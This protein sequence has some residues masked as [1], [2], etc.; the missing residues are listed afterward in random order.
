SRY[1]S[2]P[3]SFF[4]FRTASNASPS[5]PS[6]PTIRKIRETPMADIEVRAVERL[7]GS[8]AAYAYAV[9]AGPWLFLT[10]HE[11][12]DFASGATPEVE[13][14]A[15]FPSFGAPRLQREA[16]YVLARMRKALAE[17]GSDF[18][19]SVRVDQYYPVFEAVRA[20]QLARHG[21]FGDY[22][23]PSTSV[24]MERLF[25]RDSHLSMSLMAVVPQR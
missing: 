24:L 17:F 11:A 21:E 5:S 15:Q 3:N 9:K 13:G 14:P 10:G 2:S 4:T 18:R 25:K 8:G 6:Y 7:A 16:Q 1:A 20:Y 19:H 12:F 23:P 22:I